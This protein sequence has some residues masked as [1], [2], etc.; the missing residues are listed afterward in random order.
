MTNQKSK[1]IRRIIL[2]FT[3]SF[4]ILI[5]AFCILT[6]EASAQ[7]ASLYLT[8]SSGNYTVG[9]TFLVQIR[10]NSGGVPINAA[11]GT[12]TFDTDKLEITRIS[13]E[14]SIFTLWVKE[15]TFSNSLGTIEFAGGVPSP[16]F[17][18]AAGTVANIT[19]RAKT[20]GTANLRFAAGSVL[21]DD[22]KGTNILTS[23]GTGA[24][25]FLAREVT[26][27]PPEE[28]APPPVV[29]DRVPAAPIISS[30][31]HPDENKWY[32]NNNP[33]FF[34]EL[35]EGVT[36][37][38]SLMDRTAGSLPTVTHT[39]PIS[40]RKIED[41]SDG[42]WYFHIRFQNQHGWGAVTHRKVLIDTEPPESFEVVVDNG[43]DPANPRPEFIFKATDKTSGIARYEIILNGKLYD[44]VLPEDIKKEAFRPL[45][46]SPG[47]YSLEIKAFD[48][49]D[50]FTSA[51]TEFEVLSI[52]DIVITKI[53]SS[54]RVGELL[55]VEGKTLPELLVKIY[56]Q[57]EG[58]EPIIAETKS[59]S[60]GNFVLQY[61]R[62]LAQGSYLVWAQGED[63][64]GALTN[65]SKKHSLRVGLPAFLQFGKIA[66]DY[67]TTMITLIILLV[68]AGVIIFYSWYRISM[69]RRRI[70]QETRE[71]SERV[72][73]AFK[74]LREEVEEQ[75]EFLDGKPG[76]NKEERQVRDKLK[77]AL[78][79]SEEFISKEVRDVE[80]ELE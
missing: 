51:F 49:A 29:S 74:A 73:A 38:R 57:R 4:C 78:N 22:G 16:G 77:E 13:R 80:K 62:A 46:L 8:P 41:L 9:N 58:E 33:E 40:K 5:C 26:P 39:P 18:G 42:T 53:P 59:D 65:P 6:N 67:L 70:K 24:Y 50:N 35:P 64:R 14:G 68:G 43:G 71:V 61:D 3:L 54:I 2:H 66:L 11:D 56:I 76:M 30:P 79:V 63:E 34:W 36:A 27:I 44:T 48:K 28:T 60:A 25:T 69:W 21:A 55:R 52:G 12:L 7:R 45:Q 31:T 23:M 47:K 10:L 75:I 17:T 37:V 19:F 20:A 32:S 72:T 15:P 1:R